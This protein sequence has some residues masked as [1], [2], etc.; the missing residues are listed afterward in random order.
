MGLGTAE[1]WTDV[2]HVKMP[3]RFTSREGI[4]S[5]IGT[6]FVYLEVQVGYVL[7]TDTK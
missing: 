2:E 7:L 3:R 1:M 4:A 6:W 5:P